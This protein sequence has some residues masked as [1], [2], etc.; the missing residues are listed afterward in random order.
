MHPSL[1][2]KTRG[3][4]TCADFYNSFFAQFV[5]FNL[6][7]TFRKKQMNYFFLQY[8]IKSVYTTSA[9]YMKLL[10]HKNSIHLPIMR[11]MKSQ[12]IPLHSII[13]EQKKTYTN[14]A[15][16]CCSQQMKTGALIIR[17]CLMCTKLVFYI[18]E[19]GKTL[20]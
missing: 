7:I 6:F 10:S 18:C 4:K 8:A 20:Q 15:N 16:R 2:Y 13:G 9:L 14:A 1:L 11:S 12:M 3:S 17:N 5:Y 19:L